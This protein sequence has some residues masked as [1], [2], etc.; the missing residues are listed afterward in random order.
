MTD[1]G[2]Q[3]S[4][5]LTRAER[6]QKWPNLRPVDAA[7]LILID[8]TGREP[9]VLMGKRRHD[10]KF[11]PGKFVFPGGRLDAGDRAMPVTGALDQRAEARLM[12]KVTRPSMARARALALTAIRETFEETGLL[13]GTRDLGP[14]PTAPKGWEAF[15][16]HGVLPDLEAMQ[17]VARAITPPRRPKRFDTR[18][19]ACDADRIAHRI[20]GAVG[21]HAELTELKWLTVTEALEEDLPTVTTVVIEE[22]AD[23]IAKGFSSLLPVPYYH[24]VGKVFRRE[25]L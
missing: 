6:E 8:R 1:R 25:L 10:L 13:L 23:R 17:F 2:A 11:M 22:L 18:F 20:E 21:P 7:T 12:D 15:L 14:P 19:F 4:E 24:M 3:F 5:R 9:K 16:E